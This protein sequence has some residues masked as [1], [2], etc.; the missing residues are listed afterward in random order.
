MNTTENKLINIASLLEESAKKYP[1][2][3]AIVVPHGR[4]KNGKVSYT[5]YTFEQLWKETK[6]IAKA[7]NKYGITKGTKTVLMV[8]PSLDFIA[9]VFALL[10]G[11]IVPVIIDPGLGIKNLK[12]CISEVEPTAFIG[13]TKAHIARLI[14]G[15]G[16]ETINKFVTVGGK[17]LF[18]GGVTLEELK[19]SVNYNADDYSIVKTDPEDIAAIVFTS[20]STGV[21]KGVVY[22]HKNFYAEVL[23]LRDT[24]DLKPGEVDLPTLPVFALFDPAWGVTSVI[25][26]MDFTKPALVDPKKIIEAVEDFGVTH[27]FGS[28]ALIN[29]V[30]RYGEENKVKL[31]SL[32][33]VLSAGAPV[34]YKVLERFK[35]MLTDE[36]EV[37]TP[38]GA[39]ECLPVTSMATADILKETRFLTAQGKGV[40]IGRAVVGVDIKIIK[41]SDEPISTWDDSLIIKDGEI[42]EIVVKGDNVTQYYYNRKESTALAKIYEKDGKELRHR[43]GDLGYFDEQGRIWFCGRKAHRVITEN[44]T[45]FTIPCEAIYNTHADVYRSALVGAKINGKMTP[46]ICIE[47][48]QNS[49]NKNKDTIKKELLEIASKFDITKEIKYILFNDSFPVDIRH[50]SKIFREKLA[51][52]AEKEL[53]K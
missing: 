39:T 49:K 16:K 19:A 10:A 48:D 32:K 50:N 4:D 33:R 42:G 37:Y 20:G 15:W 52:W 17:K 27:M 53:V 12:V 43:M 35:K 40:C 24:Y 29:R 11:G 21:P 22:N 30:G 38:Y 28:P 6:I 13:I 36:A 5:H 9:L 7:L 1:Y 26:D 25:P 45:Y 18:W 14:M 8:K 23:T 47:V 46:V 34:P 3:H 31:K 51:V 41:I 44:G 2:R